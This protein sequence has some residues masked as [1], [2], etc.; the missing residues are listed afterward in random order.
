MFF[1]CVLK[2]FAACLKKMLHMSNCVFEGGKNVI[3]NSDLSDIYIIVYNKYISLSILAFSN[4]Q[5][6]V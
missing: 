4:P 5:R 6:E 2:M 3:Q 1:Q